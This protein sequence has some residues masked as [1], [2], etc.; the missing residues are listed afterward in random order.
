MPEN[1]TD[2]QLI[3]KYFHTRI[4]HHAFLYS[5]SNMD[6]RFH[7]KM[8]EHQKLHESSSL[9]LFQNVRINE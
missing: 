8:I 2:L 1:Y 5:T 6:T 9:T 7:K 4:S 3:Y